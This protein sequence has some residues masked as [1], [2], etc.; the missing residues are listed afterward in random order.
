MAG[1]YKGGTKGGAGS[2]CEVSSPQTSQL[3]Q[4]TDKNNFQNQLGACQSE[5][6]IPVDQYNSARFGEVVGQLRAKV[7]ASGATCN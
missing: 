6:H 2:N 4:T 5:N 7:N 1:P 3:C